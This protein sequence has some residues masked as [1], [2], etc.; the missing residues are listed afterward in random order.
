MSD[1]NLVSVTT[2]YGG[3]YVAPVSV[4]EAEFRAKQ[5]GALA[6]KRGVKFHDNPYRKGPPSEYDYL[7]SSWEYGYI[8]GAQRWKTKPFTPATQPTRTQSSIPT[9]RS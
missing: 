8:Y 6:A 2:S 5:E 3:V 1:A 7:Y 4:V 9:T